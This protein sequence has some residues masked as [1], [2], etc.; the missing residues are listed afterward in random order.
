[1]EIAMK[2][3]VCGVLILTFILSVGAFALEGKA[4]I[5]VLSPVQIAGKQ[6]ATGDYKLSYTGSGNDVQ[7]TL[8]SADKKTVVTANAKLVSGAKGNSNAIVASTDGIVKE[9]RL[10]GKSEVLVF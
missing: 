1:M 6:V 10:A 7:V 3:F 4:S 8:T 9:I 2:R 5:K